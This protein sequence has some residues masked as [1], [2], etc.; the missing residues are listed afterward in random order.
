MIIHCKIGSREFFLEKPERIPF[1]YGFPENFGVVIEGSIY[2]GALPL[3]EH[4]DVLRRL[5]IKEVV[6]LYSLDSESQQIA[7]LASTLKAG[8]LQHKLYNTDLGEPV[9][10]E[11][12]RYIIE[13]VG[14]IVIYLHCAGGSNRTGQ[15]VILIKLL[16]GQNN[17]V[18]LLTEAIRYGFGWQNTGYCDLLGSLIKRLEDTNLVRI[19]L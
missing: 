15:I 13:R 11:A 19:D 2:R 10:L 7:K 18:E 5:Y 4:I 12:A 3:T 9:F 8:G 1:L 6:S 14:K 16:L 17:M